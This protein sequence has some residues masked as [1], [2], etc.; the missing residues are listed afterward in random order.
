VTN[1]P[2]RIP[3][4]APDIIIARKRVPPCL[5]ET[6]VVALKETIRLVREID[7]AIDAHGDRPLK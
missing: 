4:G 1:E 6:K 3:C 2:K 7:A 5:I